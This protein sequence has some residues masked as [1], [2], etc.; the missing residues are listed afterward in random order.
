MKKFT[1]VQ[2]LAG[3]CETLL[4]LYGIEFWTRMFAFKV[5][6]KPQIPVGLNPTPVAIKLTEGTSS[7]GIHELVQP[8]RR[9]YGRGYKGLTPVSE[10]TTKISRF[11][12][13][14]RDTTP[15]TSTSVRSNLDS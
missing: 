9:S 5:R 11:S 2:D 6:L 12:G 7:N 15:G 4:K 8:Q 14:H 10:A 1:E 3:L 13:T